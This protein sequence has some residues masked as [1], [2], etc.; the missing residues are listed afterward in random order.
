[1]RA[2]KW[3]M[4]QGV[5]QD[6]SQSKEFFDEA[7]NGAFVP[8]DI[9]RLSERLCRSYGINGICDPMYIANVIAAELGRGNGLGLFT[10]DPA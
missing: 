9:R 2:K 6:M 3:T 8:D 7:F 4:N 10:K 1:M 5:N